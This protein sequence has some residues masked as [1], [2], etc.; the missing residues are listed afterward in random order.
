MDLSELVAVLARRWPIVAAITGLTLLVS[1]FFAL[2]GPRAYE[3]T[4]RLAVSVGNPPV[5]AAVPPELP[6]YV[7]YR[8]YYQWLASEYLADDLSEIIQSDLFTGRVSQLINEEVSK[9]AIKDVTRVRKTHRI[10]D[11]TIQAS[12]PA[13]AQRIAAAII[14]EIKQEGQLFLAELATERG[15][16]VPIDEPQVKSATTTGSLAV[17]I[18]LRGA[19]GLLAGVALAF[20]V[21]YLDSTVRSS[22]EIERTLG[23]P[24]LGEIPALGR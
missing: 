20:I 13:L 3:A 24:V 23:L 19:L 1:A 10:L 4:V 16:V 7:Y 18:G 22:R 21:D 17:D 9:Q 2:R 15:Q 5:G 14:Q 11:V 8:D 6:P 12:S